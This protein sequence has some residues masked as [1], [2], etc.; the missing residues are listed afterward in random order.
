[1][2]CQT[3]NYSEHRRLRL[4]APIARRGCNCLSTRK[5][6]MTEPSANDRAIDLVL[7]LLE[8]DISSMTLKQVVDYLDENNVGSTY[9]IKT[10]RRALHRRDRQM[11]AIEQALPGH[12]HRT[13]RFGN[14][15]IGFCSLDSEEIG[16]QRCPKCRTEN[17]ALAILSGRCYSCGWDANGREGDG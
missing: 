4:C 13:V 15:P 10:I 6:T 11:I 5:K 3:W 17:Y 1:M 8:P 2:C 9:Q 14:Q 12:A 16:L 7:D